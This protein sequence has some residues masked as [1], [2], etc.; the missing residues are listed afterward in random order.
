[1][2]GLFLISSRRKKQTVSL[3]RPGGVVVVCV[4]SL[5]HSSQV[6]WVN[7]STNTEE[8]TWEKYI[9]GRGVSSGAMDGRLCWSWCFCVCMWGQGS[10]VY[11]V[12][13]CIIIENE[14]SSIHDSEAINVS[15]CTN[16]N[17]RKLWQP[18][19]K[20]KLLFTI[21][22]AKTRMWW[23]WRLWFHSP[24]GILPVLGGCFSF[25]TSGGIFYDLGSI[26][27]KALHAPK[28]R[29]GG[30]KNTWIT[31]AIGTYQ[32]IIKWQT[33]KEGHRRRLPIIDVVDEKL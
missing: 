31:A 27:K 25:I 15:R 28:Q 17:E 9:G 6:S 3:L 21:I 22:F 12:C 14:T 8:N 33:E 30:E 32:L 18:Q 4:Q 29:F 19:I 26:T 2:N 11:T 5:S 24:V 1:M 20:M 23:W 7:S 13:I 10:F 16:M